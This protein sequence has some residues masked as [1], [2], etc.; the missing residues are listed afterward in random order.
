MSDSL[1]TILKKHKMTRTPRL[2]KAFARL[3]RVLR[4]KAALGRLVKLHTSKPAKTMKPL[5]A[6]RPTPTSTPPASSSTPEPGNVLFGPGGAATA[7]RPVPSAPAQGLGN[8]PQVADQPLEQQAQP[9][10]GSG[11]S[12]KRVG[13]FE[14]ISTIKRLFNMPAYVESQ[15]Q[16]NATA[17]YR[18]KPE[19]AE[20][21]KMAAGAAPYYLHE[22]AHHLDK[23][24]ALN[25]DPTSMP[26]NV[27]AGLRQ[28]DYQPNRANARVAMREGFAEWLR[29]R[30]QD[31]LQTRT[32]EQ[33]AAA[34]Y[35]ENMLAKRKGVIEKLDRVRD[36]FR[37]FATQTPSE[38]FSGLI[39]KT[40]EP[41]T[42]EVTP[43]ETAATFLQRTRQAAAENY[44]DDALAA[45]RAEGA[46][47]ARGEVFEPGK[48]AVGGYRHH[49]TP[50]CA[51]RK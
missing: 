38:Q 23:T 49:A 17:L 26:A 43:G 8:L 32:P 2:T 44:L 10:A 39:S 51:R 30:S 46:A 22:V 42:P 12:G 16:A 45:K 33:R 41:A 19:A 21:Q 50:Q 29:M 6:G 7:A 24:L 4:A 1:E 9:A 37:H 15:L 31:S 5:G 28:F 11:R 35:L 25:L 36:L 3:N 40:G 48:E 27:V 13:P 34:D 18:V 14:L 47:Q 20:V